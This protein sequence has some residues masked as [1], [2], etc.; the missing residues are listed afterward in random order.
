MS[1]VYY[2]QTAQWQRFL[3]ELKNSYRVYLPEEKDD[4]YLYKKYED[5]A[6]FS[7]NAYRPVQPIK[8]FLYYPKEKL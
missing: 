4:D 8:S 7:F 3:A 2:S 6:P 5:S 1:A